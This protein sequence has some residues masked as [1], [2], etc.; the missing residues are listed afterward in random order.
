[1]ILGPL[2]LLGGCLTSLLGD[3]FDQLSLQNVHLVAK[4][5]DS[6][7]NRPVFK[8]K[9]HHLLQQQVSHLVKPRFLSSERET[10]N[11]AYLT[12]QL[13]LNEGDKVN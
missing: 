2:A 1:M 4:S 3:M 8:S 7:V 10:I 11:H 6:R 12:G 13:G 5:S 9:L